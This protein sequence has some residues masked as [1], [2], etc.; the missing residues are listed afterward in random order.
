MQYIF[1]TTYKFK[2]SYITNN[3]ILEEND[4]NL[5]IINIPNE[6]LINNIDPYDF[7]KEEQTQFRNINVSGIATFQGNAF[8]NSDVTSVRADRIISSICAKYPPF[9]GIGRNRAKRGARGN[10]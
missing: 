3:E 5:N 6:Y 10:G 8:F 1:T 9:S 4:V 7:E 2:E